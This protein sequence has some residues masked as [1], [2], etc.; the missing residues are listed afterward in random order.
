MSAVAHHR[1]RS[2]ATAWLAGLGVVAAMLVAPAPP[3]ASAAPQLQ[4]SSASEQI[5]E[6]MLAATSGS[7]GSDAVSAQFLATPYGANTLVGSAQQPEQLVVE[8]Q[9]VDCFTYADYVE[10]LKRAGGDRERFLDSLVDVRYR[11]GVV[12]FANRKH[13]FTDW[14]AT[15]PA[16]ATDITAGL[17]DAAVET[18]KN[19]NAKDSGGVYLPGLPVVPRTVW[20]IPSAQ[21]DNDVVSRLRTGDYIGAYAEDGGLDVTHVGI[22]IDSPD[23]PV[24]RNASSRSADNKVVD[25]A[26]FDYLQ[27]VPAVVVLRPV[28]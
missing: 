17:S 7:T 6:S 8:L 27:T 16:V 23:G 11:D 14:S 28:G 25:T 20:H 21:V 24:F 10:A 12:S 4:I 22:F 2:R 3:E 26:L 13:F 15:A 9:R 19:L 5:L 18:T 1:R